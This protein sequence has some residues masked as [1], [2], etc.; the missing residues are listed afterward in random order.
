MFVGKDQWQHDFTPP[1][2]ALMK[3]FSELFRK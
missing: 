3:F 1:E 2:F